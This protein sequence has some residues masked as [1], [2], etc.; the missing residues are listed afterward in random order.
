M[1]SVS[2][3]HERTSLIPRFTLFLSPVRVLHV[4]ASKSRFSRACL[5]A[6]PSR[7]EH[8]FRLFFRGK[9]GAARGGSLQMTHASLPLPSRNSFVAEVR[10]TGRRGGRG[11]FPAPARKGSA[12]PRENWRGEGKIVGTACDGGFERSR[13]VVACFFFF[14]FRICHA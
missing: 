5:R 6:E 13:R 9:R 8:S 4:V 14:L 3:K 11:L 10:I 1:A 7:A 12:E 2:P